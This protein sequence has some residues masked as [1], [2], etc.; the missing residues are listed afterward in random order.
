M[1]SV[2]NST[3]LWNSSA[4]SAWKVS[5]SFSLVCFAILVVVPY[6]LKI[7]SLFSQFFIFSIEFTVLSLWFSTGLFLPL[8]STWTFYVK[9]TVFYWLLLLLVRFPAT[10][11]IR[12]LGGPKVNLFMLLGILKLCFF[13]FLRSQ[14][15]ISLLFCHGFPHPWQCVPWLL[16][17]LCLLI[18]FLVPGNFLDS[19]VNLLQH[20]I[21][22]FNTIQLAGQCKVLGS[23]LPATQ[24]PKCFPLRLYSC[25]E[26]RSIFMAFSQSLM[27]E[28]DFCNCTKTLARLTYNVLS[29]VFSLMASVKSWTAF[30]NSP[31]PT[32]SK[33]PFFFSSAC[34]IISLVTSKFSSP[35]SGN[36]SSSGPTSPSLS[37]SN[38]LSS[39]PSSSLDSSPLS[40]CLSLRI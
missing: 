15:L 11:I 35:I 36:S 34:F 17:V 27:A 5:L 20:V 38:S 3:G 19:S 14:K 1:A 6:F 40:N 24:K 21:G 33:A 13:L 23:L 2:N 37:V 9:L 16:C 25:A 18:L 32:A 8:S 7:F 4:L 31:L 39:F 28:F 12:F 29:H 26:F 10:A 22:I 30:R